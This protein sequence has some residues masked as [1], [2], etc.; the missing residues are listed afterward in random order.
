VVLERKELYGN[1][2][3]HML[4]AAKFEVPKVDLTKEEAWPT[5]A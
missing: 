2:L 5:I 4:D 3:L 1:E